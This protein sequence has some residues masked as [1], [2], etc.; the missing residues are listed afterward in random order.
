M[1]FATIMTPP[2][3]PIWKNDTRRKP[4]AKS[5]DNFKG[6]IACAADQKNYETLLKTNGEFNEI[7]DALVPLIRQ[8]KS[9]DAWQAYPMCAART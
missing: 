4:L 1:P 7:L 5:L 8:K 9:A 3:T 2:L 6:T